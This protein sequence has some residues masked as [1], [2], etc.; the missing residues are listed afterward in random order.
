M[1]YYL[2]SRCTVYIRYANDLAEEGEP[3]SANIFNL[4]KLLPGDCV[5]EKFN[6]NF[7]HINLKAFPRYN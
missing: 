1:N 4:E 6:T 7:G 3:L 2:K 5:I